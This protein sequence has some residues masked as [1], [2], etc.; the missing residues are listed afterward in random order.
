MIKKNM[1]FILV[2][3]HPLYREGIRLL[4]ELEGIGEVI[5]EAENGKQFLELLEIELPDM[6]IMDIDMPVM[7]GLEATKRA[8]AK[9]PDLR[10]LVLSMHSESEYYSKFIEAGVQGFVLKT[11]NKG[12]LEHAFASIF[13]GKTFFSQEL[14]LNLISD[15][16]N[17]NTKKEIP[18]Y[19]FSKQEFEV[20]KYI[21]KGMS[22]KEMAKVM[23]RS[24]KTI[25]VYRSK[26]LQK[27]QTKNTLDLALFAIKNKI[28]TD[29]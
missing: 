7:D 19:N 27:T 6:V 15:L 22:A 1:K 13:R 23:L 28:I 18:N 4:I 12:E 3:D 5:A 16:K 21:C 2:D 10:I 14:L 26:L 17:P 29:F 11:A 20:L 25:E 8:L 24:P 9:Y